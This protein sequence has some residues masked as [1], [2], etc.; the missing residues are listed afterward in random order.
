M[1]VLILEEN[2]YTAQYAEE[3]LRQDWCGSEICADADLGFCALEQGNFDAVILGETLAGMDGISFLTRARKEGCRIPVLMLF[4]GESGYARDR[5]ADGSGQDRRSASADQ[6]QARIRALDSGADYCLNMPVDGGELLA[7]LK[8]IDRRRG[9]LLSDRLAVGDLFLDQATFTLSGPAGTLQLGKR[10]FDMMRL[11]MVN[12]DI[13]VSKETMLTR[14]WG[15]SA[16]AGDNNVEVY[17]SFLRKKLRALGAHAAIVTMRRL[18]Y[19]LT[20]G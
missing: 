7:V 15:E 17:I 20:T 14:I 12:R 19:K 4:S 5:A 3:T 8:A 11:L 13:V 9:N 16:D 10:E 2:A 6:V 18:G 1:R